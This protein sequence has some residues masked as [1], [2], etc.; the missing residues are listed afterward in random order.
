MQG[1]RHKIG[2]ICCFCKSTKHSEETKRKIREHAKINPSYGMTGKHHSE[3][4]KKSMAKKLPLTRNSKIILADLLRAR[5][6]LSIKK[7]A[8][9]NNIAWKTAN[10]NIRKLEKRGAIKCN[11]TIRKTSCDLTKNLRKE[12]QEWLYD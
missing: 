4:S 2:C 11:R 10:E 9:R 7:I 3:K 8:E 6:P 12:L 5:R 1:Y